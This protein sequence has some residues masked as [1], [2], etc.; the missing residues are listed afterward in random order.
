VI[1]YGFDDP[2]KLSPA[3]APEE[4]KL[5]GFRRVRDEIKAFVE[6]LPGFLTQAK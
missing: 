5:E 4:V 1:H 3:D 6:T 2:P